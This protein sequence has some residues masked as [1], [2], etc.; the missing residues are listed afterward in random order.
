MLWST[1]FEERVAELLLYA[2]YRQRPPPLAPLV[3]LLHQTAT[4]PVE[5]GLW[6]EREERCCEGGGGLG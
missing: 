4:F 2:V 1:L 6:G 5:Q 3:R